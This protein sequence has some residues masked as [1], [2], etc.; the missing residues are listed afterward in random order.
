MEMKVFQDQIKYEYDSTGIFHWTPH[1]YLNFAQC[2]EVWYILIRHLFFKKN[3]NFKTGQI[4]WNLIVGTL[5][6]YLLRDRRF[7]GEKWKYGSNHVGWLVDL[8][9]KRD[10]EICSK[11]EKWDDYIYGEKICWNILKAPKKRMN[12]WKWDGYICWK[13]YILKFI[14]TKNRMVLNSHVVLCL[15]A[16][17]DR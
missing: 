13:K 4:H 9:T 3:F 7:P 14:S 15:F 17:A 1:R 6:M 12:I 2:I 16:D 5:K 11:R 10:Q 8:I